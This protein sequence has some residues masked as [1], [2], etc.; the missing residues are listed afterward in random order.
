MIHTSRA[1]ERLRHSPLFAALVCAALA[2]ALCAPPAGA[3]VLRD[4]LNRSVTVPTDPRRIITLLPSLTETVCALGACDRLVAVGRFD[5]WPPSVKRLPKVG[6]L[7][8]VNIER[9]VALK[10]DLVLLSTSQRVGKRLQQLGVTSFAIE[11]DRYEDI[12]RTVRI[13]GELLGVPKRAAALNERIRKAVNAVAVAARAARRGAPPTVYFEVDPAPYAAGPDSY[14][15]GLLAKLGVRNIVAAKLG[16]FPLLNPEYVVRRNPD[17]IF[18]SRAQAPQLAER[19]GWAQ[20]KAVREHHICAFSERVRETIVR[21]G[22]RVAEGL[23]AM[24][25]CLARVAP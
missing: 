6:D 16:A 7:D 10:P 11:T 12:A 23:R 5:D 25:A 22:P 3:V 17:V 2:H 24:A 14:I 9:I 1:C 18:V 20:M 8:E 21:P 13:V 19:P 4:D 15:G